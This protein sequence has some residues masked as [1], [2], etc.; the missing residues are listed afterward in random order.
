M[1]TPTTLTAFMEVFSYDFSCSIE[2]TFR[3]QHPA[4][5]RVNVKP[6]SITSA[7][8]LIESMRYKGC[9]G[10]KSHLQGNSKATERQKAMNEED[11]P[12]QTFTF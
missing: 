1:A 2:N 8:I 11:K 5:G 7:S 4:M 12:Q 10:L 9:L 6:G 3:C